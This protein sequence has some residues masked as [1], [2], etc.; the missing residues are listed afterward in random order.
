MNSKRAWIYVRT[1]PR[2][3]ANQR[4]DE[5][6]VWLKDVARDKGYAIAGI[7]E[8]ITDSAIY[9]RAGLDAM[10]AAAQVGKF[11]YLMVTSVDR[12]GANLFKMQNLINI[13]DEAGIDVFAADEYGFLDISDPN[14]PFM[15]VHG[16]MEFVMQQ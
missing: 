3:G 12:L 5:Q 7:S 13:L 14:S 2:T 10:C 8:D 11:D 6:K 4:L 1:G 9:P 16:V 15:Q